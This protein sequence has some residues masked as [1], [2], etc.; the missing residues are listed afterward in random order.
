MFNSDSWQ[1]HEEYHINFK[2]AKA[3]F[4]S[5]LRLSLWEQFPLQRQKLLSLNLDSLGELLSQ[6]YSPV[7]RPAEHQAQIFRSFLL[8]TML[9]NRTDAGC[10]LTKWVNSVLP[11]N[12][13]LI[14]LIGCSS[15][16]DL[17]PLGSYYDLMNRLWD[18]SRDSYKNSSLLPAFKNGKKPKKN[19]GPDG[20]LVEPEP[21]KHSTKQLV[22]QILSGDS[23]STNPEG[24]LQ[25]IFQLVAVLPS[26]EKGLLSQESL[27]L[28]GDGTA[29]SVHS[30]PFGRRQKPCD[31]PG[32]CPYHKSC[33][34][35]YSDPDADWGWDSHE[36]NWYF[37]RSLYM[38]CS[39]NA[40]LKVEV[41]LSMKVMSARRHDSIL[42][43]HAI[44]EF[45]RHSPLVPKNVCL[46]SAHDN[47][48][49]YEL[50]EHWDI[51]ALIDINGRNTR[52]DGLPPD[53]TLDKTGQPLCLAG[54]PMAKWGFEKNKG[55]HKYRCPLKCGRVKECS[56]TDQCSKSS[57]GRTVYIKTER[58]LRFYPRIPRDSEQYRA[59]YSERSA[60]ERMNNRFLNDYHLQELKIRGDDHYS[61]W[62]MLIGICIHLDA[63][64]KANIL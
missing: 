56:C 42:F 25:D 22:A 49:T 52:Y 23:L 3:K 26:V 32:D 46:D 12:P 45:R 30:S 5:E 16:E 47:M 34:R 50:L 21:D 13:V 27:T 44:Q 11:S 48:P 39:R 43:L 60:C 37:G 59:I 64:Y 54:F 51:N 41:P 18:G 10:S 1:S 38:L 35:H 2:R 63:R 40:D 15:R 33:P 6:R 62:I 14:A 8:F 58:N 7:G 19:I 9:L 55:G 4:S 17:P 24:F 36:K 28:S 61:F 53:I 57:Y 29:L 31:H 20:K